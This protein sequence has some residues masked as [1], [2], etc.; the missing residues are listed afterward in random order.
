MSWPRALS[1]G[2]ALRLAALAAAGT[3]LC[4][5]LVGAL[6]KMA[7]PL[8]GAGPAAAVL[9]I[10]V[11]L[12]SVATLIGI[13]VLMYALYAAIRGPTAGPEA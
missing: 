6:A 5:L 7:A 12:L 1:R 10:L 8:E 4:A 13:L 11:L 3:L 9:S 2:Q